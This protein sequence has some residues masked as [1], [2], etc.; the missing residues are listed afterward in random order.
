VL[1]Y[2]SAGNDRLAMRM[3]SGEN[4]QG[5]NRITFESDFTMPKLPKVE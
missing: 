5:A 3:L 2:S 4:S 1:Q